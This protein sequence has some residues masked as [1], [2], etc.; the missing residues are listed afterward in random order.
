MMKN[1][2]SLV[3]NVVLSLMIALGS[4]LT[5]SSVTNVAFAQEADATESSTIKPG[6]RKTRRVP[7]LRSRVYDQLSRAQTAGDAGNVAEAI[8]ILDEVRDKDSSMNGYEK[9]MMY[10][11]WVHLLQ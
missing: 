10:N 9:S 8:E 3:L 2:L 11:L 6:E 5:I 1:K 7:A 4:V